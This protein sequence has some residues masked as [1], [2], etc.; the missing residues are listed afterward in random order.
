MYKGKMTLFYNGEKLWEGNIYHGRPL[1][2]DKRERRSWE[3][4]IV[5]P[6]VEVI[7]H[8]TFWKCL[9]IKSVIMADTV[10]RI[11]K[12]AFYF[13]K[14][15]VFVKLST[16]L[17][18]I[19]ESVFSF[20]DSLTSIFIPPSCREIGRWAFKGCQTLIMLGLPQH[21]QLGREVFQG[22]ALIKKSPIRTDEDG[23]Y[24]RNDE[25][26]VIEWVKS[27]NNEEVYA[28]H[29]ASASYN[30]LSEII[31]D[32]VKRHGINA[33]R[34]PNAIGITP[35]QYLEANT[36]VDISEKDIVNRYILDMMGETI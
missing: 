3:V 12:R 10:K 15:V 35:S 21:V 14:L 23:N 30:P 13:C 25:E 7:P 28:L 20:C 24:N 2:Y 16:N 17:E 9:N 26:A 6:G 4:I 27:I 5:L 31:H 32:Q 11:E 19:G 33:M 1:I 18:Y 8:S 29:R 22:T 36:F 34:M